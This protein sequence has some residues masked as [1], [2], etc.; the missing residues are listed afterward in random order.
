MVVPSPRV[1]L[2]STLGYSRSAPPGP[3]F[4]QGSASLHPGLFSIG[5]SGATLHPG[6]RFAPPWAI[7]DR[8]LRG[9]ASPRVSLRS[10]LGYSRSAPPGPRFTQGFASLH[11]GLFSIGPSG[12]ALHPGF[13]F[14]P[15]WAIL[16]RP[17]RGRA[18]PRV[19]L[20]STLGYS[21]S[22]PPG[23]RFTQGFASLHPGLFSIGPSGAAPHPG[24]RFA[25]PWAILDRP[26]RGRASI[27][28]QFGS[29]RALSRVQYQVKTLPV[30]VISRPTLQGYN[31]GAVLRQEFE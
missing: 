6:F 19:S 27:R 17:L 3:R 12:A 30:R 21:R 18:S 5:P 16:D 4:T 7:L 11:P 31:Q 24:F 26:L 28:C 25:P 20:R 9:H 29:F 14:A 1:P 8:P 23:P 2:R 22:A 15:P 13:R 10:T